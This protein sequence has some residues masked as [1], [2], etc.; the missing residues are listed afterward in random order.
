MRFV[1]ETTCNNVRN[2]VIGCV[3]NVLERAP[4]GIPFAIHSFSTHVEVHRDPDGD[5]TSALQA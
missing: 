4:F 2:G 5:E 3:G 1:W